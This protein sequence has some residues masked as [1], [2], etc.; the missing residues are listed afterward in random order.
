MQHGEKGDAGSKHAEP[1]ER[2]EFQCRQ[3][4]RILPGPGPRRQSW[5]YSPLLTSKLFAICRCRGACTVRIVRQRGRHQR[6]GRPRRPA[7]A[8]AVASLDPVYFLLTESR[9]S[10]SKSGSNSGVF[11]NPAERAT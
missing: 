1:Q 7:A 8:L 2:D 10:S 11:S 4:H 5:D 6:S 3:Q 9:A